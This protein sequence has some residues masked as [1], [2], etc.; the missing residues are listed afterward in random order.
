MVLT[1]AAVYVAVFQIVLA[2]AG[3]F[4][5]RRI[6]TSFAIGFLL[7]NIILA[8]QQNIVIFASFRSFYLPRNKQSHKILGGFTIF[9]SIVYIVFAL[10]LTTFRDA[11]I[12]KR[13]NMN[14]TP[15]IESSGILEGGIRTSFT[16]M[17]N[18]K[19]DE[20]AKSGVIA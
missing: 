4:I 9:L 19:H 18:T 6:P 2:V 10:I 16:S 11:I 15:S 13:D 7:G 8:A 17:D 12:V 20:V 3:T 1:L 14:A 5:L